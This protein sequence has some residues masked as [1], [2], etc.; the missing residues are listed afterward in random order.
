MY[1]RT[2]ALLFVATKATI[3]ILATTYDNGTMKTWLCQLM[4]VPTAACW[5]F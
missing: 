5:D 3:A 2:C 4:A 1:A